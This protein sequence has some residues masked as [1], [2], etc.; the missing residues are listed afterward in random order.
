MSVVIGGNSQLPPG[1]LWGRR[2][3]IQT[4]AWCAA[5]VAIFPL[6]LLNHAIWL[7]PKTWNPLFPPPPLFFLYGFPY[8]Q[9]KRSFNL[10]VKGLERALDACPAMPGPALEASIESCLSRPSLDASCSPHATRI[11]VRGLL[12]LVSSSPRSLC[13]S[14][15]PV[16]VRF[17]SERE[18]GLNGEWCPFILPQIALE[19]A[20]AESFVSGR[21]LPELLGTV[22]CDR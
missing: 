15:V 6:T 11:F 18:C 8:P 20:C 7:L 16:L 2:C 1:P 3:F 12:S 19:L 13:Q 17:V 5:T 14:V 10:L 4:P 9:T 21:G 22:A